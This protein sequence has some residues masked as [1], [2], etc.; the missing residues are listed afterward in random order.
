MICPYWLPTCRADIGVAA[1]HTHTLPHRRYTST[2]VQTSPTTKSV[3]RLFVI[4]VRNIED[5]RGRPLSSGAVSACR[6]R[7]IL[8]RLP[9][10]LIDIKRAPSKL[11]PI[12]GLHL[13]LGYLSITGSSASYFITYLQI[14]LNGTH[15]LNFILALSFISF[16]IQCSC[17]LPLRRGSGERN[18]EEMV[19]SAG[20]LET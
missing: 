18:S 6:W 9:S 15:L 16:I 17:F 12:L 7:C 5:V 10:A 4:P 3:I 1:P 2:W 13:H 20:K 11:V 14:L 19:N 8:E